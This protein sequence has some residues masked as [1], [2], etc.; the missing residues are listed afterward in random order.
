MADIKNFRHGEVIVRQ[1]S[2]PE[3]SCLVMQG[4]AARSVGM[5]EGAR[6]LSAIHL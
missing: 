5:V 1:G 6:Q 3:E 2:M 4:F